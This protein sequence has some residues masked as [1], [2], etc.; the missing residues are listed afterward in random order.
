MKLLYSQEAVSDLV[1]L[2]AFIASNDP[3]AAARIAAQLTTRLQGLCAFPEMGRTV[4]Q[5]PHPAAIRDFIFGN[6]VV[7]YTVQESAIV[8]LRLWHH[9]ESARSNAIA[10]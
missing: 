10:E 7:R 1:R 8:I 9:Y 6:Y 3:A 4:A 2:R 5:A